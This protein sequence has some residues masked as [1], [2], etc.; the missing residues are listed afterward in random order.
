M[1]RLTRSMSDGERY[2]IIVLVV[3]LVLCGEAVT[4]VR[5][6][7]MVATTTHKSPIVF[8]YLGFGRADPVLIELY[9]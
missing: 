6:L 3:S 5:I 7:Y 2:V 4:H 8:H 1:C 9:T